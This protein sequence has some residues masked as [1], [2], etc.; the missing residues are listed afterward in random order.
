M[1]T[2]V[3]RVRVS[4][5]I[6]KFVN[7]MEVGLGETETKRQDRRSRIF[8]GMRPTGRNLTAFFMQNQ[9]REKR[10]SD[11]QANKGNEKEWKGQ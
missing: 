11:G 7:S 9:R 6:E 2:V 5:V 1:I 10:F 3:W 8:T 4:D